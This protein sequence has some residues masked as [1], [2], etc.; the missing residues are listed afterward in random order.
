VSHFIWT[1]LYVSVSRFND[2]SMEEYERERYAF[3]R[4]PVTS[5]ELDKSKR[6]KSLDCD[7]KLGLRLHSQVV[8]AG[9]GMEVN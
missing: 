3:F 7:L 2:S 4:V 8:G 1:Y 6:P 9:W 5:K